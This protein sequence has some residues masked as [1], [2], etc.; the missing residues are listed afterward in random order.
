PLILSIGVLNAP[1]QS[2]HPG[3]AFS[4]EG[5]GVSH[6]SRLGR[7]HGLAAR[8]LLRPR[9]G[10]RRSR[11]RLRSELSQPALESLFGNFW[12]SFEVQPK[13]DDRTL[14]VQDLPGRGRGWVAREEVDPGQLLLSVPW[15]AVLHV[16]LG[17]ASEAELA[18]LLLRRLGELGPGA[19]ERLLIKEGDYQDAWRDYASA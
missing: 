5:Q 7:P 17:E 12:E 18:M 19:D 9:A 4:A 15:N 1:Y 6:S 3:I 16:P 13:W 8:R 11:V 14:D 2:K 10:E